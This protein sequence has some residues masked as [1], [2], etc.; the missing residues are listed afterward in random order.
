M[1]L[2]GDSPVVDSRFPLPVTDW[3]L[4]RTSAESPVAGPSADQMHTADWN[5]WPP[6]EAPKRDAA[7]EGADHHAGNKFIP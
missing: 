3:Q 7:L 5:E 1:G 4:R 2:P 6:K